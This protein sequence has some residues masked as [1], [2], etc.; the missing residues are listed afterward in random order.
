VSETVDEKLHF[1]SPVTVLSFFIHEH[2]Q[3][4]A[5]VESCEAT[6]MLQ[7]SPYLRD[8]IEPDEGVCVCVDAEL[9]FV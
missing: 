8:E 4:E 2:P 6:V 5:F 7:S 3:R 9:H 1:T